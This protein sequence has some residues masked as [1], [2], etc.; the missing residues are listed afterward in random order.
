MQCPYCFSDSVV[1]DTAVDDDC[2]VRK[3]RCKNFA[4]KSRFYT[5]EKDINRQEGR[6]LFDEIKSKKNARTET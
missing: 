2:V 4:C 5:I 6:K 1:V 3:R